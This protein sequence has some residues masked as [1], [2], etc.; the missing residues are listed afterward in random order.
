[1]TNDRTHNKPNKREKITKYS[2]K[3]NKTINVCHFTSS[4]FPIHIGWWWWWWIFEALK[5][6]TNTLFDFWNYIQLITR[7]IARDKKKHI[8][9]NCRYKRDKNGVL[10]LSKT[11]FG[12][13]YFWKQNAWNLA[14]TVGNDISG[15]S[16]L[17]PTRIHRNQHWNRWIKEITTLK[18]VKIKFQRK[19]GLS[20]N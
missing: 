12:I 4:T 10:R 20:A 6:S 1:M 3:L 11:A 9:V 8:L 5:Q 16:K 17:V 15:M 14:I 2:I 7:H 18:S 13:V 19:A